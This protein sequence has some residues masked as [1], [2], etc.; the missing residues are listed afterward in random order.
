MPSRISGACNGC[1][2]KKQKCSGDRSGCLQCQA[3][4][5]QCTWPEQRKRGPAKGY[6]EGL[7]HRLHEAESLILAL[8]PLVNTEQ[9]NSAADT[10]KSTSP[11]ANIAGLKSRDSQSPG[12]RNVRS[13]PPT[14]NK[15][16]GIE[17]WEA[18]PLDTAENIRKW[19]QDCT[20]H[21][22]GQNPPS[23]RNSLTAEDSFSQSILHQNFMPDSKSHSRAGS[24]E[25]SSHNHARSSS[26]AFRSVS[27]ESYRSETSTPVNVP[28]QS[29]SQPTVPTTSNFQQPPI[30]QPQSSQQNWQSMS[31]FSGTGSNTSTSQGVGI[32][33]EA[34]L[35]QSFADSSWAQSQSLD[36][37]LHDANPSMGASNGMD[38]QSGLMEV[39]TGL[40]ANDMQKRLFW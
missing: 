15:K 8:L 32:G 5:V 25:F 20:T 19:Q 14:L 36:N 1:R 26:A 29:H 4:A 12:P 17:Y 13:S 39:D 37:G 22:A 23:S 21:S 27:N 2:T 33:A 3:V 35:L 28:Q 18:F 40:F 30:S 24:V 10:L 11:S 6:I 7:E 16:T 9:L 38:M 31:L 34:L